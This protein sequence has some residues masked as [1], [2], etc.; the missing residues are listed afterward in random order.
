MVRLTYKLDG[1]NFTTMRIKKSWF[2]SIFDHLR[3]FG[4]MTVIEMKQLGWYETSHETAILFQA[5]LIVYDIKPKPRTVYVKGYKLKNTR[6]KKLWEY[7]QEKLPAGTQFTTLEQGK[8]SYIIEW[9]DELVHYAKEEHYFL[10][11]K[12][13]L[14]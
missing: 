10:L 11:N 4:E 5:G 7:L 8:V 2:F 9:N 13:G 3:K 1:K 12:K 14:I 6:N